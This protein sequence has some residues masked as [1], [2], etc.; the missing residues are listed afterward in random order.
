MAKKINSYLSFSIGT[1]FFAANVSNV[2]N[3]IEY[4]QITKVP[5]MPE[6]MLG[7]IN[8]RGQVLPVVDSGIKFGMEARTITTNTCILDVEVEIDNKPA[9]I[10]LLVDSVA[11]VMEVDEAQIKESPQIGS[12]VRNKFITGVIPKDEK[13]I[14]ILDMNQVFASNEVLNLSAITAQTEKA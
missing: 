13:F 6:Y 10:G 7:V 12:S 5:K 11:E 8:L 1:E 14:M 9:F 2:R 4:T 3:I